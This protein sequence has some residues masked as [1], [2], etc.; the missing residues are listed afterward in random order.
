MVWQKQQ[1]PF[2]IIIV[3]RYSACF[4]RYLIEVVRMGER[5]E[6]RSRWLALHIFPHERALRSRLLRWNL[7]PDLDPDDVIQEV[8]GRIVAMPS[9]EAIRSPRAYMFQMA[10]SVMLMH[11]RRAKIVSIRGVEN[12]ERF[13]IAADEPSPEQQ[14]SGRLELHRL[15]LAIDCI[16]QPWRSAFL[17]RMTEDLTHSEIGYRLGLSENAVQKGN[18]RTLVRLIKILGEGGT[19]PSDASMQEDGQELNSRARD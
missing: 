2:Y 10:R 13:D 19:P 9:V 14:A 3:G 5:G 18:A 12:L 8:Y 16:E 6:D 15:A 17:L 7:P 1:L 11:L 4:L